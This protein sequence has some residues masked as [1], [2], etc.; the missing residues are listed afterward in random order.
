MSSRGPTE[1]P[2]YAL[3]FGKLRLSATADDQR[4]VLAVLRFLSA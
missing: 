2:S 1:R 3:A 4:P